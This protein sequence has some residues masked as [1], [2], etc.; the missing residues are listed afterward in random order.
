[1][2]MS[3][4]GQA[5]QR[6]Q[7][8]ASA[9]YDAGQAAYVADDAAEF[10]QAAREANGFFH[11]APGQYLTLSTGR[12]PQAGDTAPMREFAKQV[13]ARKVLKARRY[14]HPEHG[15]LFAVYTTMPRRMEQTGYG[16]LFYLAKVD[17]ALKIIAKYEP[18]MDY[19]DRIEWEN[20]GGAE[21]DD[22]GEM[23][24][25]IKMQAPEM[26]PDRSHYESGEP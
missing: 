18:N 25:E 16:S 15:D 13:V 19:E 21:I 8:F 4:L 12:H 14:R 22:P 20:A 11:S 2:G 9:E 24:E 5:V 26:E 6:V 10:E 1:M 23:V 17:G 7:E 3:D